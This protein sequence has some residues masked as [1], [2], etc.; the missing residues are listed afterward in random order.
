MIRNVEEEI[1]RQSD[2]VHGRHRVAISFM[3]MANYTLCLCCRFLTVP[4][5]TSSR[6][7]C[8]GFFF[9]Q[10]ADLHTLSV[11]CGIKSLP[12]W[13]CKSAIPVTE[14]AEIYRHHLAH[15]S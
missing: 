3:G 13:E 8:F 2:K 1:R 6:I 12:F 14:P 11:V 15:H 5:Q 9:S 10:K 7:I 4:M